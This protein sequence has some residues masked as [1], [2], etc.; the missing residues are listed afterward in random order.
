MIISKDMPNECGKP[1]VAMWEH[2]GELWS[3]TLMIDEYGELKLYSAERDD[4]VENNSIY[5]DLDV[6]YY[7]TGEDNAIH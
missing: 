7:Y 2:N 3:N 4:W 5:S 6:T 1:F